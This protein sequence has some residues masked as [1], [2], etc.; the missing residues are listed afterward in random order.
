MNGDAASQP[1]PDTE[2]VRADAEA[3][4]RAK[5]LIAL[6]GGPRS[7]DTC[8][9]GGRIAKAVRADLSVLYV[10]PRTHHRVRHEL[11]FAQRKLT[12]WEIELPGVRVLRQAREILLAMG[13]LRTDHSGEVDTR[14][15][16]RPD[17]AGAFELHVYGQRGENIRFRLREGDVVDQVIEE[18]K[19]GDY[20]LLVIG[21]GHQRRTLQKL[22]QFSAS[23]VLIVRGP[24]RLDFDF[25]VCTDGSPESRHAA[26][27]GA[28]LAAF[29][30]GRVRVLAVADSE[31][32]RE[33]AE[34]WANRAGRLL[35][36]VPVPFEKTV[37]VGPLVDTI[38]KEAG[39]DHVVVM[40]PTKA[41][42]L[43]QFF[44]GSTPVKVALRAAVP[45]LLVK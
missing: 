19:G 16:L 4:P 11:R 2:G 35:G 1:V 10:Q 9:F 29:F 18:V 27:Y 23:S 5:I 41:S 7:A 44:L 14:H 43:R 28:R 34:K 20:E 33:R 31:E 24:F 8:R 38:V 30:G 39:S 32:E 22:S 21:A 12:E 15:E 6:A 17:V 42:E 25:L 13:L 45:V 40:G 26:A 36:R 37:R 3:P